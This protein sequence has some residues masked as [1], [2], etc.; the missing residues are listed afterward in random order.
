MKLLFDFDGVWTYP[1]MES[2][3]QGE[4]LDA[5]L[6]ARLPARAA[7]MAAWLEQARAT[8]AREPRRYGWRSSGR[9]SAFADEDPYITHAAL[10]HYVEVERAHDPIAAELW[11]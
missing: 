7:E 1:E 2:T 6:A 3:A 8:L 11:A 9:V 10:L 4:R 5:A